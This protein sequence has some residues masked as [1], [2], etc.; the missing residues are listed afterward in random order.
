MN[1]LEKATEI[2]YSDSILG[3]FDI[4]SWQYF[5]DVLISCR[6]LEFYSFLMMLLYFRLSFMG[7]F[8]L[9]ILILRQS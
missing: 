9:K 3:I 4:L 7:D 2:Y 8:D 6:G 1:G 5:A